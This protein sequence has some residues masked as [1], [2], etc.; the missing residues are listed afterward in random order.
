MKYVTS[1]AINGTAA[2]PPSKSMAVRAAAACLLANG[3]SKI[4]NMSF[5]DDALAAIGI[6]ESL[7]AATAG[8]NGGLSVRGKGRPVRPTS[9]TLDCRESA[10]CMRMFT[11]VAALLDN[12][13]KLLASGSLCSRPMRMV[14]ALSALG[15]DCATD[16][17]HAPITVK[18][19]IKGG[20]ITLDASV[21][22]Q[23]L[24]GLL[25]TLPLCEYDSAVSATGLASTPYVSMTLE[26]LKRFGVT[27]EHDGH[28]NEFHIRGNQCY[29]PTIFKVE[30]DWSGAAFLLVAGAI[31]GSI[32]VTGLNSRSFQADRAI[33]DALIDTGAHVT[34]G[35]DRVSV[36]KHQLRPFAFDATR[37]PDLVPPLACLA[38]A[39]DG[40]STIYGTERLAHKESN[41]AAALQQEFRSLG[42]TIQS[43]GAAMEIYGGRVAGS[44]VDAH[45]DHRIAMACTVA[46]LR[47]QGPV[48]IRDADCVAKSYP[49]F[50]NVL[51]ALRRPQ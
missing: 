14:E 44:V 27:V 22:S 15:A 32:T 38:S 30:G 11:P 23:L 49:Q 37:C 4:E 33:L 42:I 47:A 41:R 7:G 6:A 9:G 43:S 51:D 29:R 28:L 36:E 2:A 45:G 8:E 17:G 10:L 20:R 24:T 31:A 18:G 19:P 3:V 50:Y 5:C 1:S 12:P 35:E 48:G 13:V 16:E 39:C 25:M 26:L 40:K 34:V 46:A 21:T